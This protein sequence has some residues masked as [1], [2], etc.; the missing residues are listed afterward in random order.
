MKKIIHVDMDA[1]FAAIEIREN[2]SLKGKCVIVGGLPTGRGVVSTCSYEARQYGVRS[3]MPSH[4]AWNLCPQGIFVHSNFHLYKEVSAQIREIFQR[5]T[6]VVEPA[7]LDE[8]YLDVTDNKIDE[9]DARVIARKIKADILAETRLTCSAGV[10]FNKFLAKIASDMNKPDGL[11]II[12]HNNAQEILFAL[13]I[14]KFHGIGKV[15]ATRMEKLGIHNG[16]D[17]YKR[18]LAELLKHFGKVGHFFYNV[19]RGIDKRE[20]QSSWDPKTISCENTFEEDLGDIQLLL[21]ELH[22]ITQRLAVRMVQKGIKG[23]VLNLKIRYAS[24][25]INTR[26]CPLPEYTQDAKL[27]FSYAQKLL[28]ANWDAKQKVRLLGVG[29]GK[30]DLGK[31]DDNGQVTLFE[32]D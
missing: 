2:P 1:Y 8:A 22:L 29:L 7:S 12:D 13:P 4:Q 21:E 14:G 5:Y 9:P 11:T 31:D 16:G 28:V 26:S 17:L 20:V 15:T 19:V 18:E 3:G 25:E 24:F 6:D 10:S 23:R 30:L 27:I 32:D